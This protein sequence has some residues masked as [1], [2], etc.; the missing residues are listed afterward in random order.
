MSIGTRKRAWRRAK[1]RAL[2]NGSTQYRGRSLTRETVLK[3]QET[4]SD[5]FQHGSGV[6]FS[7]APKLSRQNKFK[8][9]P[10]Q[11]ARTPRLKWFNWNAGG[12]AGDTYD[13][14][15]VYLLHHE[16]DVATIQETHWKFSSEWSTEAFHCIHSGCQKGG[17]GG[18]LT[19]INKTICAARQI[20]FQEHVAGRLLYVRCPLKDSFLSIINIY[21]HYVSEDARGGSPGVGEAVRGRRADV[22]FRL[23]QLLLCIAKRHVL[24]LSGDM[25]SKLQPYQGLIGH[26]VGTA[27][28]E[29]D[30]ELQ[31][32]VQN[33][34]LVA[35]NTWSRSDSFTCM[36]PFGH[37]S[38]I[39]FLFVRVAQADAAARAVRH[40]YRHPLEG[41]H[42]AYHIP[43][44]ACISG[45]HVCWNDGAKL[46]TSPPPRLQVDKF[47]QDATTRAPRYLAFIE[48]VQH[49]LA[50]LSESMID[51]DPIICKVASDL[52]G[53]KPAESR[54]R[55]Q[56]EQTTRPLAIT[57]W[58][59]WR[60]I[61]AI[62]VLS[63]Q[64]LFRAWSLIILLWRHRRHHRNQRRQIKRRQ[65]S[66]FI[67]ES[68]AAAARGDQRTLHKIV[69]MMA[70][71]QVRKRM[72]LRS[73]SG[74]LLSELEEG[75]LLREHMQKLYVDPEAP[76]IQVH[77]CGSLPIYEAD[78]LLSLQ[79]LPMRKATPR[80][81]TASA[82]VKFT[83]AILAPYLYAQLCRNWVDK[84]PSIPLSWRTSW[85]CWL[86]KPFKDTSKPIGWRGI[87]LQN[88]IGK[89]VLKSVERSARYSC[90]ILLNQMPQY[91]YVAGRGTAEAIARAVSHQSIAVA[92]GRR[93]EIGVHDRKEGLCV[94]SLAGG[95]QVCLDVDKA[96]DRVPRHKMLAAAKKYGIDE[97]TVSILAGWHANTPYVSTQHESAHVISNVGV[98][99]GCVAAPLLWLL[100]THDFLCHLEGIFS[101][102][103]IR[104]HVTLYADDFHLAFTFT[105]EEALVQ[106][107]QDLRRVLDELMLFGLAVNM[108]K[109]AFLLFLRGKRSEKWRRKLIRGTKGSAKIRL[110]SLVKNGEPLLIPLC[111]EHKYLGIVLGYRRGQKATLN[112]RISVA[113]GTF[114]R[115]RRWW[116]SGF[117]LKSRVKLWYQTVWPALTY[118][119]A[120]VGLSGRDLSRFGAFVL[121][122]L[123][124]IARSP[125]HKTHETNEAL[126]Q[127]L[128][129]TH[130]CDHLCISVLKTWSRRLERLHT[131]PPSD[132]L[133]TQIDMCASSAKSDFFLKPW[134][135]ICHRTWSRTGQLSSSN[136]I[137]QAV[138]R[139][140]HLESSTG[141]LQIV[142]LIPTVEASPI[143][144]E[145]CEKTF[146]HQMAYRRHLQ[147]AHEP[148]P[149]S[150]LT[151]S[152]RL[153]S[154]D[155][156]PTCRF[157][158]L[159]FRFWQG[160]RQHL[161]KDTCLNREERYRVHQ[162]VS[163]S[164]SISQMALVNPIVLDA[165]AEKGPE[166]T[167]E[168]GR[169]FAVCY[170]IPALS[171]LSGVLRGTA[172]SYHMNRD[173]KD[174]Y[175]IGREWA[176][177]RLQ[178]KVL[179]VSNPCRW[180]LQSFSEKSILQ[181]HTCTVAV[182]LG[183]LAEKV[184]ANNAAASAAATAPTS[185]FSECTR[186]PA[187][188]R[189][190]TRC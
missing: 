124:C 100:Y 10:G 113:T 103:W 148:A 110:E 64:G 133:H 136:S 74:R 155:G 40:L 175:M 49:D 166:D 55:H 62:Q 91:A 160:L 186:R 95:F 182:Q 4:S 86:P 17:T 151:F 57:G 164:G 72:Q 142:P 7:A 39:D 5:S 19:L 56:L 29:I 132:V 145:L 77:R 27:Q 116:G 90:D 159:K 114:A 102:Q 115:L 21:Q 8:H 135:Q 67:A 58:K 146:A 157:C 144:C 121:R 108:E 31:A 46:A 96:F 119:L 51:V 93:T 149:P 169:K 129:I 106:A 16:V 177:H 89:A 1:R 178:S 30:S 47:I 154:R 105:S 165:I 126:C 12:L 76:P 128:G 127:R 99:Q 130:P 59:I 11:Q 140:L 187:V 15:L 18:C 123:R 188:C 190:Q 82:F 45:R 81:C 2:T 134:W 179:K 35:L 180:C 161:D 181:K 153:D 176:V 152:I 65:I 22:W 111:H 68:A 9:K 158:N 61:Q 20:R 137:A 36:G 79:N 97:S 143:R 41:S 147:H 38:T 63:L 98:R 69:R 83:A 43:L 141:S 118:G 84:I 42:N 131:L 32:I 87:S 174:E 80:C 75:E 3:L 125:L 117:P 104:D 34:G 73:D 109:T 44:L 88:A 28:R 101:R 167:I 53:D 66:S 172:L 184:T 122:Q 94:A 163:D 48:R 168:S 150:T 78:I 54:P 112:S 171:A 170:A 173:H 24:L 185:A 13:T 14:L 183:F 25:N 92:L 52:Y 139:L 33:H 189:Q 60:R 26:A 162:E 71:K 156:L 70:P 37:T 23:N 6:N 107:L 85:V 50:I 120:E 138:V